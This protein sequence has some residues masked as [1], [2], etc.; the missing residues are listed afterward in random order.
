M[1]YKN[2]PLHTCLSFTSSI[3]DR[4]YG[5]EVEVEYHNAIS[6]LFPLPYDDRAPLGTTVTTDGSLARGRNLEIISPP[7]ALSEIAEWF[8]IIAKR[9]RFNS[10]NQNSPGTSIHVHINVQDMCPDQIIALLQLWILIEESVFHVVGGNRLFN[11]FCLPLHQNPVQTALLFDLRNTDNEVTKRYLCN[12]AVKYSSVSLYRLLDLGTIENRVMKFVKDPT[13]IVKWVQ[14]LDN[15][16]KFPGYA[17][18]PWQPKESIA[19]SEM[20]EYARGLL[21]SIRSK[22]TPNIHHLF[23][24][25]DQ[26]QLNQIKGDGFLCAV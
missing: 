19:K 16:V 6:D 22:Q 1:G 2:D 11:N 18:D 21:T 12:H 8:S 3:R 9:Y 13:E 10:A 24:C 25:F 20:Y 26:Y 14:L 17:L 7:L 4:M 15:W 5:L 23:D